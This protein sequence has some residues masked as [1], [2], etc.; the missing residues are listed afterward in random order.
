MKKLIIFI[1]IAIVL[2]GCSIE[3]TEDSQKEQNIKFTIMDEDEVPIQIIDM[4][5]NQKEEPFRFSY[6]VGDEMYIAVGYGEQPTGGYSI[7]VKG[8]YET[9]DSIIIDTEL[10]GPSKEDLVTMALTYPRIIVK[11]NHIDKP[12]YYQ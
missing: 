10:L 3:K 12:V 2:S 1:I 5:D 8:L 9:K 4:I 6:I 7:Q 11:I